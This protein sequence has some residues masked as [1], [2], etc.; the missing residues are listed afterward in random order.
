MQ[1]LRRISK[2]EGMESNGSKRAKDRYY[3]EEVDDE[4]EYEQPPPQRQLCYND[5]DN[6][7]DRLMDD[8]DEKN[9]NI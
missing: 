9:S 3:G 5:D 2:E 6:D 8:T 4:D 1:I 7:V